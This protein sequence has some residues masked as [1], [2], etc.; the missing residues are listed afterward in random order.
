[1]FTC[2]TVRIARIAHDG[3][4]LR[5]VYRVGISDWSDKLLVTIGRRANTQ[6]LGLE[7]IGVK[8]TEKGFVAV[9][10]EGQTSLSHIYAIGD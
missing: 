4:R 9:N 8:L 10:A 2:G 3:N 5:N 1:M 7:A 6:N